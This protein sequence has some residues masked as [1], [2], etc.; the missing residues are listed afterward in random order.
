MELQQDEVRL[1]AGLS[2]VR[3]HSGKGLQSATEDSD[4]QDKEEEEIEEKHDQKTEQ[5]MKNH[6]GQMMKELQPALDKIYE[7]LES[8]EDNVAVQKEMTKIGLKKV[9]DCVYEET[10]YIRD[11]IGMFK[12]IVAK[13]DTEPDVVE[14][15]EGVGA[16]RHNM[17]K[18]EEAM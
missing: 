17:T 9:D 14:E 12:D 2:G 15:E 5:I 13:T 8:I 16:M 6:A 7:R 1:P 11:K 4:Q 18:K 3:E 10:S